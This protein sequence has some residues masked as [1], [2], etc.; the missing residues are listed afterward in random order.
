MVSLD[1]K[2]RRKTKIDSNWVRVASKNVVITLHPRGFIGF[3]E[4]GRR[5]EYKLSLIEAYRQAVVIT[6]LKVGNRV[7]E[8]IKTGMR[9]PAARRKAHSELL[10]AS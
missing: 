9:R 6:N 8:L 10:T 1:K 4:L 7:K 2:L 5:R 3:R